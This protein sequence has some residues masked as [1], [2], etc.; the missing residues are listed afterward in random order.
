MVGEEA[1]TAAVVA[2]GLRREFRQGRGLRKRGPVVVALDSVDL[3]IDPGEVM[4]L[5][6]PNG[7]GKTT[8][9]KI[10]ATVLLPSAGRA[11]VLGHDVVR[12]TAQVRP[13]IGI[14]FGGERGLYGR[15]T[16]RQNLSYWGA[17]Y[18]MDR[19]TTDRRIAELLERVGPSDR[20]DSSV[21]T[22]AIAS[23]ASVSSGVRQTPINGTTT[24][25]GNA[26]GRNQPRSQASISR[27]WEMPSALSRTPPAFQC[28]LP[29]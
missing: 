7:A 20:A 28:L 29:R 3:S 10:L 11:S 4:G 23:H 22:S 24:P 15:L 26:A 1:M 17:L 14:V 2:E 12:D 18:R 5:L 9:V 13:L 16:A 6:G 19:E 27:G 21:E 25:G 8:F